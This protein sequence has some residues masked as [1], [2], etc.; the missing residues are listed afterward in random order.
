MASNVGA[1]TKEVLGVAMTQKQFLSDRA[2]QDKVFYAKF[3]QSLD[4]FGS[5]ADAI[6]VW[7]SGK[8]LS[9]AG[10]ASDGYNTVPAY[11]SKV[12]DA[13]NSFRPG[14]LQQGV[15][16][17][18][19]D[20]IRKVSLNNA[21]PWLGLRET[22]VATAGASNNFG[23]VLGVAGAGIGAFAGGY[24]SADPAMGAISGALNGL[25]VG[26]PIGAAIGAVVGLRL[27][28]TATKYKRISA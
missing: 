3:G 19:Q 23:A 18:V 9:A 16:S 27:G 25:A 14:V 26:G 28:G 8:P 5:F 11:L 20:G 2:A 6:S 17:G 10:N 13:A 4:K 1:W 12:Q 24:Q 21:D 22:S 7:F 15:S